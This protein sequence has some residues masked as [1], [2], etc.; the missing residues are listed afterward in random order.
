[1]KCL[2]LLS[3]VEAV[4]GEIRSILAANI[5]AKICV[6]TS[7]TKILDEL[8]TALDTV[9]YEVPWIHLRLPPHA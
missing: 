4:V 5:E 3:K 8:A 1:M 7:F 2:F 6:F 9:E